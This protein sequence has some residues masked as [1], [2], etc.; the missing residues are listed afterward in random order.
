MLRHPPNILINIEEGWTFHLTKLNEENVTISSLKTMK[1]KF[2]GASASRRLFTFVLHCYH[3]LKWNIFI[4]S[5]SIQDLSQVKGFGAVAVLTLKS[6]RL[7]ASSS[8]SNFFRSTAP[9]PWS[10]R[11]WLVTC[12]RNR[13]LTKTASAWPSLKYSLSVVL[14]F[15]EYF[16]NSFFRCSTACFPDV[17]G[18]NPTTSFTASKSF[19]MAL[20][21]S[22]LG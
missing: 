8:R 17:P 7:A 3:D 11:T 13:A 16:T 12:T 5:W 20:A 6:R 22:L 15:F 2:P 18:M 19:L 1:R 4:R 10:G 9:K 21:I 14:N